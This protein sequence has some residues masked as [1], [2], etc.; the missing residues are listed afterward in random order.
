MIQRILLGVLLIVSA[1]NYYVMDKLVEHAIQNDTLII[2]TSDMVIS[3]A[4]SAI[5][6]HK[7]ILKLEGK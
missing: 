2:R 3:C 5:D 6:L 1:W 4:M 7:R